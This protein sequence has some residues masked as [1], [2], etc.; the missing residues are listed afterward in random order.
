MFGGVSGTQVYTMGIMSTGGL[1]SGSSRRPGT[2]V[3]ALEVR[4]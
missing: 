4:L 1:G 3:H 2:R